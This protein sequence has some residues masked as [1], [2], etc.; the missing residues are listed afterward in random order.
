MERYWTDRAQTLWGQYG[1]AT[2]NIKDEDTVNQYLWSAAADALQC[3][4]AEAMCAVMRLADGRT[5][6]ATEIRFST[7]IK[8][9]KVCYYDCALAAWDDGGRCWDSESG[10]PQV[11]DSRASADVL[12]TLCAKLISADE[13]TDADL[14]RRLAT[15]A[16]LA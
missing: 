12:K 8:S 9:M 2:A 3:R 1:S 16:A 14:S 7:A 15:Q 11:P 4:D 6:R 13:R 5:S 10:D